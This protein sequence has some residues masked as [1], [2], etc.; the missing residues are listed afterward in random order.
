MKTVEDL[1]GLVGRYQKEIWR[2]LRYLG[3]DEILAEDLTQETFLKIM[4][5]PF[6]QYSPAAT[7]SYLRAVARNLFLKHIRSLKSH[8]ET[9]DFDEAEAAW[10]NFA[11]ENGGDTYIQALRECL[12]SLD[13]RS[14]EA[15][16][17]RFREGDS[18]EE[19][20]TAMDLHREA[21]KT[22]LRRSKEKL[23]ICVEGKIQHE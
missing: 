19:I 3:C 5:K 16:S 2:Y 17:R 10:E 11:G 23:H 9:P 4:Q 18:Y 22:L 14:R 13:D 12:E 21:L 20:S 7:S 6:T 8:P 1:R 15:L